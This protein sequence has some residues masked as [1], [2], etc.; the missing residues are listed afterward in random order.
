[1]L[2]TIKREQIIKVMEE[3]MKNNPSV[4]ALWLEGADSTES[5]DQYPEKEKLAIE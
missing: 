2:M 3:G 5:V 1:M 4:F